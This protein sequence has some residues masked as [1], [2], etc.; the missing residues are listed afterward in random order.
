MYIRLWWNERWT[1]GGTDGCTLWIIA[2][3]CMAV[4]EIEDLC[5]VG[6]FGCMH[7]D[8]QYGRLIQKS[9]Y[10]VWWP[11]EITMKDQS[12]ALRQLNNEQH[13]DW[14][15]VTNKQ[16]KMN[17]FQCLCYF[18]VSHQQ[19]K[20]ETGSVKHYTK[21]SR[22]WKPS[23]STLNWTIIYYYSAAEG[24]HPYSDTGQ[25][26][27]LGPA[28]TRHWGHKSGRWFVWLQGI[29][30]M[31]LGMTASRKW[32]HQSSR[33]N[34]RNH[35]WK[36]FMILFSTSKGVCTIYVHL[37]PTSTYVQEQKTRGNSTNSS[38]VYMRFSIGSNWNNQNTWNACSPIALY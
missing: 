30:L 31:T 8:A 29:F 18:Y 4:W 2:H 32:P 34:D 26:A 17:R 1:D 25:A 16:T 10:V 36:I 19:N 14:N 24:Q 20:P 9:G 12:K 13:D 28:Q 38:L 27:F 5:I 15:W 22:W 11:H 33:T 37:L 35:L 7:A 23:D 3:Q 6:S 21:T